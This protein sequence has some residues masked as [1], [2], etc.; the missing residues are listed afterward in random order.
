M[1]R[2]MSSQRGESSMSVELEAS[3][4][5]HGLAEPVSAGESVKALIARAARKCGL[6]NS[7]VKKLW[8]KE[9]RA[10]LAQEMDAL[11]IAA[12]KRQ[13]ERDDGAKSEFRELS[14]RI[15][16]L[17]TAMGIRSNGDRDSAVVGGP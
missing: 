17:E 9:A 13:K 10:I 11:R 14:E 7:R 3:T 8:Y 12:A 1:V 16:R 15:A 5:L 6:P 4:L 2:E